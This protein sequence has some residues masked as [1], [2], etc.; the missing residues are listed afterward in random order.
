MAHPQTTQ[1]QRRALSLRLQGKTY[2]EI[3]SDLH[4]SRQRAQQ[5]LKAPSELRDRLVIRAGAK[6]EN[7]GITGQRRQLH[8]HHIETVGITPK[9]YQSLENLSLLCI[10]C[11]QTAHHWESM[12]GPVRPTRCRVKDCKRTDLIFKHG[13]CGGHYQRWRKTGKVGP[14][15]FLPKT[16]TRESAAEIERKL[17]APPRETTP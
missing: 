8:V 14:A 1:M 6:C 11:H 9:K 15:I 13:L 4:V 16:Y 10:P 5:L 7:C 3:A 2:R 17:A 12:R